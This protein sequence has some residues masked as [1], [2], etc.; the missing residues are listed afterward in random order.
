MFSYQFLGINQT[1]PEETLLVHQ[2]HSNKILTLDK[3]S[4][5]PENDEIKA[6]AIITN[7]KNLTI[8]IKTADCVPILLFSPENDFIIAAIHSG[9]RGAKS[10]IIHNVVEKMKELGAKPQNIQSFIGPC[11]RQDSYQVSQKFY[12]DFTL[13]DP[14][15]EIFFKNDPSKLGH[16]LFNL[17]EFVK[18][19]LK[20]TGINKINDELIDTYI[21]KHFNSYRAFCHH[22]KGNGRNISYI[23]LD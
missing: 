9:W 20:I 16:F 6:D 7:Q 10:N 15:F 21:S 17:P 14:K 5:I 11:I 19:K 18:E 3:N 22:K 4:I 1:R 13:E 2:I 8:G 23:K 12:D